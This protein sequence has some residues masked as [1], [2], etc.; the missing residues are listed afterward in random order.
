MKSPLIT[1]AAALPEPDL[2][3]P[4]LPVIVTVGLETSTPA[5]WNLIPAY[6]QAN[7]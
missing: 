7:Q 5:P 1:P 6:F 2:L 4:L 3:K